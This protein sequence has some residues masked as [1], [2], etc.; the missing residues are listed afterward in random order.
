MPPRT[1]VRDA[2]PARALS[3]LSR[4]QLEEHRSG[5]WPQ[6]WGILREEDGAR[7]FVENGEYYMLKVVPYVAK[8]GDVLEIMEAGTQPVP[9]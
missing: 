7:Q 1:R 9:A 5:P 2:V 4:G 8:V 6:V 3:C